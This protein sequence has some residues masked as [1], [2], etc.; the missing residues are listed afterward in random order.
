MQNSDSQIVINRFFEAL[1]RLKADHVIR[2][3]Q[4]FTNRY[5]INRW[6]LITQSREPSRDM[7]QVA[8]L[9]YLVR[10]FHVSPWWILSGD[11]DFYAH[12]WSASAVAKNLKT[13]HQMCTQ[14]NGRFL[15]ILKSTN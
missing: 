15:N 8:W 3:L 13:C 10:D 11:G 12:G 7:F 6:N 2:G 9:S 5:G 4:T 1:A 14:R